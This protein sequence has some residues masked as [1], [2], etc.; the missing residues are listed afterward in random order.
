[1]SFGLAT[2]PQFIACQSDDDLRS[3]PRGSLL[4]RISL[5]LDGG[6]V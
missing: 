2:D 5:R 4:D 3:L 1:M 6:S